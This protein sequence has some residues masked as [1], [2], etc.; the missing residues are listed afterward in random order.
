VKSLRNADIARQ[1]ALIA[2]MALMIPVTGII[3][4]NIRPFVIH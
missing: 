2:M 1:Q 4:A 3:S